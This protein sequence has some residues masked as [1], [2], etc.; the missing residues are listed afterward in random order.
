MTKEAIA[1]ARK[2]AEAAGPIAVAARYRRSTGKLEVAYAN[3]VLLSVPV[4]LIQ[5]LQLV[6]V[7]SDADLAKIEIWGAGHDLYFPRLDVFVHTPSLLMGVFG[8]SA[9]MRELARGLG[10]AKSPAKAAAARANGLKGGRPPKAPVTP[11]TRKAA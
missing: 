4:G 7:A 1:E 8:T 5:E 2:A 6:G 9:W 3:G 11:S 10:S